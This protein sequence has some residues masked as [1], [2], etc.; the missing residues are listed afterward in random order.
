MNRIP[1][2]VLVAKKEIS[3]NQEITIAYGSTTCLVK[4]RTKCYCGT[5]NCRQFIEVMDRKTTENL[6]RDVDL[7]ITEV[8][9]SICGA[10]ANNPDLKNGYCYL[11]AA[12][13]FLFRGIS[14]N[15]F[16]HLL[17]NFEDVSL[18]EEEAS[19]ADKVLMLAK[20]IL[21][22][23]V[24]EFHET[25]RKLAVDTNDDKD[26]KT[27]TNCR[28]ADDEHQN[29]Y[30]T[31]FTV[32]TLTDMFFVNCILFQKDMGILE[33][34]QQAVYNESFEA[35]HDLLLDT[36]EEDEAIDGSKKKQKDRK[37]KKSEGKVNKGGKKKRRV[38]EGSD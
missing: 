24:V 26:A 18:L 28:D 5:Q 31:A 35:T 13:Q 29:F 12:I 10:I 21:D 3:G 15:N 19:N 16:Q 6:G 8:D 7:V 38:K 20:E 11:T 27:R 34:E 4:N 22:G 9:K 36:N 23:T 1:A 37:R 14:K 32:S 25:L 17:D 33:D 30:D 2:L